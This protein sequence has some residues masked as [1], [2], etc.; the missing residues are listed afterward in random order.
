MEDTELEEGEAWSYQNNEDF[1]S[2]IDPDI[3]LSYI[4]SL[5]CILCLYCNF[6]I[7]DLT[8]FTELDPDYGV[9]EFWVLLCRFVAAQAPKEKKG[10]PSIFFSLFECF[11]SQCV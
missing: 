3:A 5:L 1:D 11:Y 6:Q 7:L 4:V 9:L 10:F 2:N 8:L